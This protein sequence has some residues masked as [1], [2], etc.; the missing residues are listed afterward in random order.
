MLWLALVASI[1]IR[2]ARTGLPFSLTWWSFTFPVGTIVTG[3]TA[4]A[5]RTHSDLFIV[6]AVALCALLVT[7]WI[8]VA[9]RTARGVWAGTVR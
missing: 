8:T 2:T 5:A 6:A 9:T 4:L 7:A 1:T 3:T